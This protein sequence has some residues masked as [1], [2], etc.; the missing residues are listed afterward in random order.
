MGFSDRLLAEADALCNE[1]FKQ[2]PD[3]MLCSGIRLFKRD[4]YTNVATPGACVKLRRKRDEEYAVK[5]ITDSNIPKAFIENWEPD[6]V[7][8]PA[9]LFQKADEDLT[10][11][12]W[13][14]GI[15]IIKEGVSFKYIHT[16]LLIRRCSDWDNLI[17]DLGDKYQ[18]VVFDRFDVGHADDYVSH[19]LDELI[20]YRHNNGLSTLVTYERRKP[21]NTTEE[22][23]YELM[24]EWEDK[25]T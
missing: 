12:F 9:F 7:E 4:E 3:T 13:T 25:R 17:V 21:R 20:R 16:H 11:Q 19:A 23:L 5:R 2:A 6:D 14:W 18:V 1:C 8:F 10:K 24:E 22:R 15:G